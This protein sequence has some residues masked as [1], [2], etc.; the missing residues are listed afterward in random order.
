MSITWPI[1]S[2]AFC[3]ALP[4][5]VRDFTL[6]GLRKSI[7]EVLV[8][9]PVYSAPYINEEGVSERDRALHPSGH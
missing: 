8:Q 6:S 3:R 1:C 9:F 4:A 5:T 2:N 7:L